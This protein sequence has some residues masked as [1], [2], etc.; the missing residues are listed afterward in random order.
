MPLKKFRLRDTEIKEL[1]F[2]EIKKIPEWNINKYPGKNLS[3]NVYAYVKWR[4]KYIAHT[5][6]LD[7]GEEKGARKTIREYLYRYLP[8]K[9]SI[10][11]DFKT[12]DKA[13]I[14]YVCISKIPKLLTL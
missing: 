2:E 10:D 14:T 8:E 11:S 7:K 6:F 12:A 13:E 9:E 5:N 3:K 1:L 4:H